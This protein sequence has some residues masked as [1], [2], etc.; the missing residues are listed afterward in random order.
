MYNTKYAE[1][2]LT[3]LLCIWD[4]SDLKAQLLL[5]PLPIRR[6]LKTETTRDHSDSRLN[7]PTKS[8]FE[9]ILFGV[10]SAV[11]LYSTY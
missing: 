10:Q 2:I 11:S 9:A 8:C 5:S 3:K 4:T 6:T 1:F 7:K